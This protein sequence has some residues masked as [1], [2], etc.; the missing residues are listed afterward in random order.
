MGFVLINEL[1]LLFQKAIDEC[2]GVW[3]DNKKLVDL[4][5]KSIRAAVS[6]PLYSAGINNKK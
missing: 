4:R 5:N 1:I 3:S 6:K 2:E